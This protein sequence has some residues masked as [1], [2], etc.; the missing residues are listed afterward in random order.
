MTPAQGRQQRRELMRSIEREH[1]LAARRRVTELRAA[2]RDARAMRRIALAQARQRCRAERVAARARARKLYEEGMARLREAARQERLAARQACDADVAAARGIKEKIGRARAELEAERKYQRDM[3][4]IER[5][6]KA[7]ALE[8]KRTTRTARRGES[9]DEVRGNIPPEFVSL[10]E[11]VKGRIKGSPRMTRTEA[12]LHY[13]HEHPD[14]VLVALEDKTEQLV[15]E[16]EERERAA[17]KAARRRPN[18]TEYREAF[19]GEGV[20]F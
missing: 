1:R 12:F 13:A 14:E 19:E 8:F 17:M 16:L 2:L 7:R 15:R 10:F 11:R 4:R 18:P 5:A 20:P 3:K 9:D 6:N